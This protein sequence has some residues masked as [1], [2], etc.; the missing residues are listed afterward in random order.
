[1][2]INVFLKYI[3]SNWQRFYDTLDVFSKYKTYH[4]DAYD[5][6]ALEHY[7]FV[8]NNIVYLKII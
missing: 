8:L 3:G 1:M 6:K 2:K 7:Y 5:Q 4:P